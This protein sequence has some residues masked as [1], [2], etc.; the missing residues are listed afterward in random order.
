MPPLAKQCKIFVLHGLGG[1]GKTQIAVNFARKHQDDYSAVF[2]LDGS[3]K[4]SI[5]QAFLDIAQRLPQSQFTSDA[6]LTQRSAQQPDLDVVVAEVLR[7]L[8][9][10]ANRQWLL[11]IDNV[12]RDFKDKNKDPEA[13]DIRPCLPAADHGSVL[14]T[15]RLRHLKNVLGTAAG[16]KVDILG[17][18]EA[19]AVLKAKAVRSI[20]GESGAQVVHTIIFLHTY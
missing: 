3:S 14:I 12:D 5:K 2:W 11:I 9:E 19:L 10:D 18:V 17:D 6:L 15:S 13:Y 16:L 20:P 7:W 1:I 8:S 4:D